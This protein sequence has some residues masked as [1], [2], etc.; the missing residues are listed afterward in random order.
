MKKVSTESYK[1][2]RDFYPEDKALQNY[3]IGTMRKVVESFGYEEYDASVLEYSDLYK[4]KTSDEIVNDQTYTFTD[5][6]GREV[7]MRPEMTPTLAR[8]IAAKHKSLLFPIR[9]YSIPNF[10]RYER[11]QKGRLREFW[12]LNVDIF[13]IKTISAEIEV[14]E[15]AF[16]IMEAFGLKQEH[17][18]IR[19]N[20]RVLIDETLKGLGL[21]EEQSA[22]VRRLIDRKDKIDNFD[23][24][25][26]A[27]IGKPLSLDILP[28]ENIKTLIESL[29]KRGIHN[30]V[31]TPTLMRGFDYYTGIVFEVFDTSGEN[32]RALFGGGRY[33]RLLE[34]F[35]EEKIPAFGFGMGDV[36]M[37]DVLT[38]HKLLPSYTSNAHLYICT[39]D[40]E[41]FEGAYAL[42]ETLRKDGINV[43]VDSSSKKVGSQVEYASKKKIPFIL[44]VGENEL[45]NKKYILKNLFSGDEQEVTLSDIPK[46]IKK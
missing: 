1:G 17:F 25:M 10:F 43:I 13:G 3:I 21:D 22:E 31:F 16:R 46:H 42:A 29:A 36:T 8:M 38:T 19:I 37:R 5:R 27:L 23:E 44:C 7:T 40:Q 14:L 32:S 24:E 39:V 28:N 18:K 30:V 45:T 26:T 2:V 33:D 41:S 9:W 15:I 34:I 4:S 12:Q 11:P 35:G 20:D 6:G